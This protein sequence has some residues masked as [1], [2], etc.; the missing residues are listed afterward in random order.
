VPFSAIV[1]RGNSQGVFVADVEN[2]KAYFKPVKTGI[3]EGEKAEVVEPAGLSGF[4]VTLGQHLLQ[5]GMG[6]ILPETG[7]ESGSSQAGNKFAG[8][9]R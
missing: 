5:D 3:V 6:I 9:R 2:K 4:V 7:V 8:G 1:S